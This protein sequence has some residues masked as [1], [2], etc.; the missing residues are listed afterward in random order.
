M[1]ASAQTPAWTYSSLTETT[2][3]V[4]GCSAAAPSNSV[5][6]SPIIEYSTMYNGGGGGGG[7]G[8]PETCPSLPYVALSTTISPTANGGFAV[9]TL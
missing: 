6:S 7:G 1:L 9:F 8:G 4:C 2:C 5:L 3:T